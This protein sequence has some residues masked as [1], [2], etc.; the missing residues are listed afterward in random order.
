L[1]PRAIQTSGD[2]ASGHRALESSPNGDEAPPF[3]SAIVCIGLAGQLDP[4]LLE[5]LFARARAGIAAIRVAA[6]S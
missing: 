2:S 5:A 3:R 1:F 6:L 4:S